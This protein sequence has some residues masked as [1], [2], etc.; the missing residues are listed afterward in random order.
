[1]LLLLLLLLRSNKWTHRI[2][3]QLPNCCVLHQDDFF[4]TA[5]QM[6]DAKDGLKQWDVITPLPSRF[7][8]AFPFDVFQPV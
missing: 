6:E 1:L 2:V 4:K 3:K 7:T 8:E 5:D